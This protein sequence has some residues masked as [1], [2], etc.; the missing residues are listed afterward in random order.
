MVRETVAMETLAR[1]ATVRMSIGT[2]LRGERRF[3]VG[4]VHLGFHR[5]LAPA[6]AGERFHRARFFAGKR[7][8]LLEKS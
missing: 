2:F 5:L 3:T 6:A 1:S 4:I 8:L 7:D